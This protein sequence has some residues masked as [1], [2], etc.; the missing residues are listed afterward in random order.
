MVNGINYI[1]D[2]KGNKTGIILDLIAFR[3]HKV[4]AVDVIIAL[5]ELQELI[6]N[7]IDKGNSK[8]WDLAKKQ[9]KGLNDITNK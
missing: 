5:S 1:T 4:K 3:K 8:N 7:T 6:D 2:E 9:L